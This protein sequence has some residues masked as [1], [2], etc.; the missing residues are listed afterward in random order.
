[1]MPCIPI[2]VSIRTRR[3]LLR[4]VAL[5]EAAHAIVGRGLGLTITLCKIGDCTGGGYTSYKIDTFIEGIGAKLVVLAYAGIVAEER[6]HDDPERRHRGTRGDRDHI[7]E[8]AI[9]HA[10]DV[11]ELDKLERTARAIVKLRW[12]SIEALA[13][14]IVDHPNLKLEGDELTAALKRAMRKGL[15][16]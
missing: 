8:L 13:E 1:M 10:I 14:E 2:E 6:I 5:H 16:T 3:A 9:A 11:D 4:E 12:P 7:F 15:C